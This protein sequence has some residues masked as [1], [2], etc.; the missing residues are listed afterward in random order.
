MSRPNRL[1]YGDCLTIMQGM[2]LASVDLIYLDPPFNSNRAYNA[3]YKDETGRPLPDQVEAFCDTWTLDEETERQLRTMPVLMRENG[4][5]DETVEFWRLWMNALRAT[6]PRM[7]AYLAYMVQRLVVMKGLLKPT[8]SIYLH[9][10]P[11]GSH[12]IKV[13]MDGIFGHRNFLNEIAW[14]YEVGGRGKKQFA[15]KHDT[16]LLYSASPNYKFNADAVR[17]PRKRTN[18][19]IEVDADGREWQ[20]KTDKATGRKY[21]YEVDAGALCPDWWVGIQQINREAKERLGYSTQKPLPLL[22]RIIKASSDEG[23]TVLDPFCGCATALEAAHKLNRRWIGNRHSHTRDKA[24][25]ER[26][27]WRAVQIG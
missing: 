25:G 17:I 13:M 20:V 11:T 3:I 8:G 5:A 16:L 23:D 19:K 7:L 26:E 2:R 22:E 4:I 15:K 24:R 9:C 14:C 6:N 18:M 27:A 21:R 12:Y 10:D 1:Y